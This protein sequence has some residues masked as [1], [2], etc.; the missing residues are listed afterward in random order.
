MIGRSVKRTGWMVAVLTALN[1][2]AYAAPP[3]ADA[4]AAAHRIYVSNEGS[5]DMTVIDGGT[6][7]VL[8]TIK[9]GKRPRGIQAS[10]DGKTL[11]IALT[12]R[13]QAPA[14][15]EDSDLPSDKSADGIG[16]V[17]VATQKLQRVIRGVSDPEQL[18]VSPDGRTLY[19][20]SEDSGFAVVLDVASGKKVASIKMGGDPEG[21]GVTSKGGRRAWV[22][23]EDDDEICVIDAVQMRLIKNVKVGK[24]P[25]SIIF[26]PDESVGYAP[27][28]TD[29]T[30]SF[31]DTKSL[32]V[33]DT[34]HLASD[35]ARPMDTAMSADGQRLYV[36]TGRGRTVVA[37]DTTTHKEVQSVTVGQRPWGL[38]LSPDG[39]RIYTANGPSND[40]S[41]VDVASFKVVATVAVGERP[42]G[43]AVIP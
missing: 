39:R 32:T 26:S 1:V 19:V 40:I 23:S 20:A 24:R 43:V 38:A 6:L 14:G 17:D 2:A 30:I 9:L 41:V 42:W 8:A 29:G 16:V 5:G 31:I 37:I 25:R 35:Q 13:P 22:T 3:V 21:V 4:T 11:F 7:K 27:G 12:G 28:E 18:A 15:K 34:I 36:T 33:T 10:P